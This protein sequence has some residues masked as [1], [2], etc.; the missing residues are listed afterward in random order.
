MEIRKVLERK[1]GVK[2]CI[3]PKKSNIKGGDYVVIN[4][5]EGEVKNGRRRKEREAKQDLSSS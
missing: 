2:L 3:V 4:K 5:F 1:D